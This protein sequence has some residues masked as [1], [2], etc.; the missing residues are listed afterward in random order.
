MKFEVISP[1]GKTVASTEYEERVPNR[2]QVDAMLKAGYKFKLN[3]K[4][5][6]RKELNEFLTNIGEINE[7][8]S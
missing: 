2:S 4:H 8:N 5:I 7:E 3:G 6:N 1:F